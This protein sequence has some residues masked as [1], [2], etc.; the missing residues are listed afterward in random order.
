[1]QPDWA[2][3][4]HFIRLWNKAHGSSLTAAYPID[5]AAI[6]QGIS[7][8]EYTVNMGPL[9]TVV[10]TPAAAA[11]IAGKATV[12][13]GSKVAT[14]ALVV[15]AA[16]AVGTIVYAYATGKAVDTVFHHLWSVTQGYWERVM[17]GARRNPIALM[18]GRRRRRRR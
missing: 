18:E 10:A 17:R 7:S 5:Q 8:S 1:M 16:L 9:R 12:S 13:T 15:P 11:S 2:V 14:A 6:G 4:V 3:T